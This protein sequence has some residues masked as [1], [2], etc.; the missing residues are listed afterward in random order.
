MGVLQEF[1]EEIGAEERTLRRAV[2]AGTVRCRRSG[3]RRLHLGQE[4]RAYLAGHWQLLSGL[5]R[6][7]RTKPNARL[8]VLYG[9]LARGDADE[10]SDLDLAVTLVDDTPA[11]RRMLR[12]H[13]ERVVGREVDVVSFD[14]AEE[15][16]L[17]LDQIVRE[18]RVIVDREHAWPR[19]RERRRSIRA[20]A[21]RAYRRQMAEA[22]EALE[23]LTR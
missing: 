14:R 16:P 17:L 13:L 7:L 9:S 11:E 23:E 15:D 20:R 2:A 5:R 21:R 19:L 10:G 4:E 22:V 18:G 3:P 8:A 12:D 6:A 1:A